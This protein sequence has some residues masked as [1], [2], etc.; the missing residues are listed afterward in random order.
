MFSTQKLRHLSVL[1]SIRSL[2]ERT[3][4]I[5]KST[6]ERTH[7]VGENTFCR[8]GRTVYRSTPL[9]WRIDAWRR[10]SF[11]YHREHFLYQRERILYHGED[12]LYDRTHIIWQRHLA[13]CHIDACERCE[14]THSTSRRTP[15]ISRRT[16]R[17]SVAGNRRHITHVV[18]AILGTY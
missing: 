13:T 6:S 10:E 17:K 11:L 12:I 14:R 2:S 1:W 8:R 7:S 5:S 16:H 3:L 18:W 15:S 4:S 9:T